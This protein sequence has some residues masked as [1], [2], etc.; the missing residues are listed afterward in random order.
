MQPAHLLWVLAA[1]PETFT[2]RP[3]HMR[4]EP[5]LRAAIQELC[6]RPPLAYA[7]VRAC[8][9]QRL[10]CVGGRA[11]P[12]EMRTAALCVPYITCSHR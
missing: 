7:Q 4:H 3:E 12:Q 6:D 1:R 2:P 10:V 5:P 11:H 9:H 8:G